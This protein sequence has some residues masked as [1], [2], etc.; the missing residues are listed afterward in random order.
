VQC[1]LHSS[2][3]FISVSQPSFHEGNNL[4]SS[5]PEKK[6]LSMKKFTDQK[7]KRQLVAQEDYSIIA[8]CRTKIPA[9]YRGIFGILRGV[10]K[11]CKVFIP[12]FFAEALM[13]FVEPWLGNTVLKGHL[14][15]TQTSRV[16]KIMAENF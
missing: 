16:A 4:K 2:V 14:L 1:I 6:T 8:N 3:A 7:I 11:N 13:I 15:Q 9:K 10:K 12:R 5:Y